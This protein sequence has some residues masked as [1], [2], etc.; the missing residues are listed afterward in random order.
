MAAPPWLHPCQNRVVSPE[1]VEQLLARVERAPEF[2]AERVDGGEELRT[3]VAV[4]PAAFNPPTEAHAELLRRAPAA[5]GATTPAALLTTRNVDKG[6][7]GASLSQRIDM[8]L[9]LREEQPQLAVLVANAARLADQGEALRARF[10]GTTFDFV[11]GYDTLVRLFEPR[12]YDDMG[13]ALESFFAHHRVIAANRDGTGPEDIR[14]F[15]AEPGLRRYRGRVIPLEL[16]P[17]QAK[18]SS[19]G[20]RERAGEEDAP[21]AQLP[22]AVAAYVARTG[23]YR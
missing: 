5:A 15:L 8:L 16:D 1:E 17:E 13:R 7:F 20:F 19:S 12:Y 22:A 2:V 18:L 4:L 21:F 11:V 14:R 6:I 3:R 9:A 10:P 23:L